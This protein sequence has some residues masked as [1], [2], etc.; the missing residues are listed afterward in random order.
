MPTFDDDSRARLEA[1]TPVC[2]FLRTKA[3]HVYGPDTPD[4][5]TTS[6]SS[7]YQCLKTQ[8]VCGPDRSPCLPEDCQ[9]GRDCFVER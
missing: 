8:F 2:R 9:P 1:G 5:F 7:S 4:A 3:L 6:R